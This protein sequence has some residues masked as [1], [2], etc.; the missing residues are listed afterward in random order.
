LSKRGGCERIAQKLAQQL[1]CK[2]GPPRHASGGGRAVHPYHL[3][4]FDLPPEG[5]LVHTASP[6]CMSLSTL[7][8]PSQVIGATGTVAGTGRAR[9]LKKRIGRAESPA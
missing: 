9:S 5:G 8:K 1:R 3:K 2:A 7:G 6:D 4:H